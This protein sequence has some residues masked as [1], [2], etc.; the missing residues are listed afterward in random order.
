MLI[1]PGSGP[2][3]YI[4]FFSEHG[5]FTGFEVPRPSNFHAHLRRG[6]QMRAIAKHLMQYIYYL[7]VMPNSGPILTLEELVDYFHELCALANSCGC[8]HVKFVMTLFYSTLITQE[9]IGRI[10]KL[11]EQLG[12]RIEVKWYPPEP[13]SKG[14][15]T[16]SGHGIP[17]D[18]SRDEFR[19]MAAN[20]VPLLVHPESIRDKDGRLLNPFAGEA[21]FFANELTPFRDALPDLMICG[22][23]VNTKEGVT[24]VTADTSGRSFITITPHGSLCTMHDLTGPNGSLWKCKTRLQTP[25][26]REAVAAFMTSGDRRCGAGDDSAA[27][28]SR[29]K[30]VPFDQASNGVFWQSGQ[31]FAAYAKV[32]NDHKALDDRYVFFTAFNAADWRELARPADEDIIRFRVETGRDTLEPVEVPEENDVVLPAGW[33]EQPARRMRFGLVCEA[34]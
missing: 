32:F 28:L 11:E 34:V 22:E 4:R 12:I 27:H 8:G 31:T 33:A 2:K 6:A 24:W 14:G 16:G 15:T 3:V 29:T 7:L 17:L 10:K 26:N 19:A 18:A 13:E 1:L 9:V 21:Y 30:L 25:E 23:H 5:Q 20:R